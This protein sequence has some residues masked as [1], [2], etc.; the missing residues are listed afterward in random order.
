MLFSRIPMWMGFL[1]AL[2]FLGHMR[3]SRGC[4]PLTAAPAATLDQDWS[5]P[6]ASVQEVAEMLDRINAINISY[7]S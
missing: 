7:A 4:E 5:G 1:G 6:L 3:M 2:S